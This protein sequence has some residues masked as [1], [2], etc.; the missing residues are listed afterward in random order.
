MSSVQPIKKIKEINA[1]KERFWKNHSKLHKESGLSR[2]DYCRKH[3]LSYDQFG[4]W[5]CKWRHRESQQNVSPMLLPIKINHSMP[6]ENI[7]QKI[8]CTLEFKKGYQ[9]QIHDKSI[10]TL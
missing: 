9:L 4:Y 10:V 6:R 1:E 8:L 5:E 7:Q 3:Q 2:I